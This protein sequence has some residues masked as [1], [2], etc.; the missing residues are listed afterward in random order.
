MVI[1]LLGA[2]LVPLAVVMVVSGL[3]QVVGLLH[4]RGVERSVRARGAMAAVATAVLGLGAMTA[5]LAVGARPG[6]DVRLATVPALGATVAVLTAAVAELTWPR[7]HGAVRT[8][9][10]TG[11]RLR[12]SRLRLLAWSGF[13]ATAAALVA[14]TL[15]AEP[16]GRSFG[17][18][19]G[20]FASTGS[21]Y[22]GLT[23]AVPV[24]VA[25]ALLAAAT[26]W[27]LRRADARP[28]LGGELSEL[29]RAVRAAA[30]VRILRPAAAGA[31]FTAAGLWLTLGSTVTRVTQNL[32][33]NVTAAPHAPGDWV[34]DAGL[35]GTGVG[36]LLALAAV[37]ALFWSAPALPRLAQQRTGAPSS[38]AQRPA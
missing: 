15:T 29:D 30:E 13:A 5:W 35:V 36:M 14:G 10:L 28:A 11:R 8:A 23:Y 3:R 37:V 38:P 27:A 7:P 24:G 9:S 26:W 31:L 18:K 6:Q 34:Q 19:F 32:R 22:P 33:A 4:A 21:P 2:V 1:N 25:T 17:R 20:D 12:P 16:D